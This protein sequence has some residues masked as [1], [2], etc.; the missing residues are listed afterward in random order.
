MRIGE[1]LEEFGRVRKRVL[2]TRATRA[3]QRFEESG[4]MW[5]N[6]REFGRNWKNLKNLEKSG[7][8]W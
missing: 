8:I 6:L 4:E 2:T 3:H 5:E 1:N 7:R